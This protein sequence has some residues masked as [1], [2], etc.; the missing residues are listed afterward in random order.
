MIAL[1]GTNSGRDMM[2]TRYYKEFLQQ[3]GYIDIVEE[4]FA[5][6]G[7]PWPKD[8]EMKIHGM[9]MGHAMFKIV[10]SYRKFLSHSGLPAQELDELTR[11]VKRDIMNV[12]IHWYMDT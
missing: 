8:K 10:D 11:Q 6:P 5:V 3:A 12:R 9:W 1:A 7:S 2:K 4:R